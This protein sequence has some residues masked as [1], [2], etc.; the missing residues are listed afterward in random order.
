MDFR[1]GSFMFEVKDVAQ[2]LGG[3]DMATYTHTLDATEVCFVCIL[4][5]AIIKLFTTASKG[6][7][8]SSEKG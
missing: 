1:A 5:A 6:Q 4:I 2:C 8:R 7:H 3:P